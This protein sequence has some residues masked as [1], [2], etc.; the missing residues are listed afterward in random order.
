MSRL[1]DP[2]ESGRRL[3]RI[4]AAVAL[5]GLLI[6][7]GG[8]FWA[9]RPVRTPM[10]DCGAAA[11]FLLD[12]RVEVRGDPANP[13]E[14]VT[15]AEVEDNNASPC[16]E[17][18]ANRARPAAFAMVGG[19]LLVLVAAA[20][21]GIARAGWRAERRG[22]LAA[23]AERHAGEVPAT[24]DVPSPAAVDDESVGPLA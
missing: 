3:P 6:A 19:L 11:A 23:D 5:V 20:F 21:E 2:P 12:G 10:Q 15:K 8:V 9:T 24:G 22:R 17:R 14:G 18:S 4:T 13:P 7:L 1:D 16:Q